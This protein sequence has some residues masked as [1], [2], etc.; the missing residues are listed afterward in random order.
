[1]LWLFEIRGE[2]FEAIELQIVKKN[3][4]PRN[5]SISMTGIKQPHPEQLSIKTS[6]LTL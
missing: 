5:P 1:M 6:Q 2:S 4:A 3:N